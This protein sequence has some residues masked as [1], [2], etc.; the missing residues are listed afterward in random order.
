M[1]PG[2]VTVHLMSSE[3]FETLLLSY[4]RAWGIYMRHRKTKRREG[5]LLLEEICMETRTFPGSEF[6]LQKVEWDCGSCLP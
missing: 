1:D 4:R 2:I 6:Q 3:M 5:L